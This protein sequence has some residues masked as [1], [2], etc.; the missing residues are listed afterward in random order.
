MKTNVIQAKSYQF[1][2]SIISLHKE[3]LDKREYVISRQLLRSG[4]SIGANIEEAI[5][6]RSRKDFISK[7]NTALMEA[8]ETR[9]WLNLINDSQQ[10]CIDL[11]LNIQ[12]IEEINKLLSLI[13]E[14]SRK[15][16]RS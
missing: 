12:Q 5:S 10:F 9:Y 4:T 8:R 3:L 6:A 16:S 7:I 15:N 2:L 13:V 14:S 11:E 1:A